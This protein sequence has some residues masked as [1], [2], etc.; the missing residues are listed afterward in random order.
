MCPVPGI[1]SAKETLNNSQKLPQQLPKCVLKC[2]KCFSQCLRVIQKS[3]WVISDVFMADINCSHGQET[4]NNSPKTVPV[5]LNRNMTNY[6]NPFL[7]IRI[8]AQS[9]KLS[10]LIRI[11]EKYLYWLRILRAQGPSVRSKLTYFNF[12]DIL[13]LTS[14]FFEH[15]PHCK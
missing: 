6:L 8:S 9:N 5:L 12:K 4:I 13:Q 7:A 3:F 1:M 15:V 11:S 10:I 2:T 14:Y